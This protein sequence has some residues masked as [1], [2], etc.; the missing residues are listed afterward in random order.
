[1]RVGKLKAVILAGGYG[2]RMSEYTES[3]P[4]PMVEVG[5]Y[6]MIVHIMD[7]YAKFGITEFIIAA[8]Y[9][10]E[11]IKKYFMDFSLSNS[12]FMVETATG[13]TVRIS[14]NPFRD[15]TISVLNTGLNTMT[16]GRLLRLRRLIENETFLLTYGDGLS[17][18]DVLASIDSHRRSGNTIT[19]T[20]VRPSA[21]FG[22]LEIE[23]GRVL[24]FKEKP[25]LQQGWINGG[26]FVVEPDFLDLIAG[27]D[28]IL[29][30]EPL[31]K[32]AALGVLGAHIHEGFWQCMDTKR[33]KD[34]LEGLWKANNAPWK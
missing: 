27:D 18:V 26:F 1:M 16:G 25:Q 15:W 14:E 24:S 20:A 30:Q 6:P 4:K 34:L 3:L 10:S 11:V 21:R 29:E 5:G 2:T 23:D 22:E 31:E 19:V 13:N 7:Y 9:K 8:G 32:A 12:D 28:T 33:D 17:N